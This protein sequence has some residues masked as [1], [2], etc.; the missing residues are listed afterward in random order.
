MREIVE[1]KNVIA[2]L[3]M[4]SLVGAVANQVRRAIGLNVEEDLAVI[5]IKKRQIKKPRTGAC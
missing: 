1:L 4:T 3:R 5:V 2:A